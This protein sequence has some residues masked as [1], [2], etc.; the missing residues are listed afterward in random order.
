M[1][2]RR[3]RRLCLH[4]GQKISSS[5]YNVANWRAHSF[6]RGV[7]KSA[8]RISELAGIEIARDRPFLL[9]EEGGFALHIHFQEKS[10]Q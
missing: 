1:Q 6:D 3:T 2:A 9:V 8:A 7:A 10:C 5:G 4:A